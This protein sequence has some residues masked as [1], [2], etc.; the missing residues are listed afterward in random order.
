M[1]SLPVFYVRQKYW[2]NVHLFLQK[3]LQNWVGCDIIYEKCNE[4]LGNPGDRNGS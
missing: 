3:A 4:S 1:S 2:A